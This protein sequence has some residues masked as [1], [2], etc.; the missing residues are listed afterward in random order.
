MTC[1]RTNTLTEI[2]TRADV[3]NH[4][5]KQFLKSVGITYFKRGPNTRSVGVCKGR[6]Q[7]GATGGEK[8]ILLR[9]ES[10]HK[11]SVSQI[12]T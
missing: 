10:N 2:Y 7:S 11:S 9:K 12:A 4:L 5:S 1:W 3:S 6:R 8:Y